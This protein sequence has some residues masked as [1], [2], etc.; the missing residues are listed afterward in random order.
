MATI[1]ECRTALETVAAKISDL[2]A[3]S[4][5]RHLVDRSVS[6]RVPDLDT[7]FL[8]RLSPEGLGG[9]SALPP[10]TDGGRSAQVRI[11]VSSDDL[12]AL[13]ADRLD[14][15][16]AWMKGRIKLEASFGDLMRLRKIL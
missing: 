3:D 6:V 10:G 13:A 16:G 2:D 8:A 7:V 9:V 14:F 11:T 4:R 5:R 12:V 15:A 1:E